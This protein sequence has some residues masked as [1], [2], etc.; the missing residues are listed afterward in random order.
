[1][2]LNNR[3]CKCGLRLSRADTGDLCMFCVERAHAQ[4]ALAKR[5]QSSIYCNRCFYAPAAYRG[6]CIS[7]NADY[8]REHRPSRAHPARGRNSRPH[9]SPR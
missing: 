2:N 7:C 6:M 4:A 3:L 9:K 1:M 8:T 5:G